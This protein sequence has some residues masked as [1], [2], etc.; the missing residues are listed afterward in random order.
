MAAMRGRLAIFAAL[1]AAGAARVGLANDSEAILAGGVL[2][3]KKS[4]GITMDSEELTISPQKVDVAYSFRNTT[5]KDITTRVAFPLAPYTS[6][7]DLQTFDDLET[8]E[9]RQRYFHSLGKFTVTVDGKRV[10]FETTGD[11]DIKGQKITVTHHWLQTFPAG[12]TLSV[13]HTFTPV[14]GF[15]WDG[16]YPDER[17][18]STLARDYCVGPVLIDAMKKRQGSVDQVHYVLKTGA[19]WDGPIGRFVLR[20]VKEKPTHK[21]S[22]CMDGFRK[23][24]ARTFVLEKTNFVPTQDLKVAFIRYDSD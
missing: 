3:F 16:K 20:I 13:K 6:Y 7:E 12:K 15:L 21:T 4:D 23:V 18:W 8:E 17:L 10:A 1:I 14:G 22:V 24:D 5:A 9:D 19:N 2:T 11:A